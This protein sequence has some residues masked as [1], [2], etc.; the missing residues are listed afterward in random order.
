[1]V[2]S[3]FCVILML[4]FLFQ[5]YPTHSL[6]QFGMKPSE[7]PESNKVAQIIRNF[8]RTY[9][10]DKN[11]YASFFTD[12]GT[13]DQFVFQKEILT[14]LTKDLSVNTTFS[15]FN[16]STS[17]IDEKHRYRYRLPIDLY[18]VDRLDQIRYERIKYSCYFQ[19]FTTMKSFS[20]N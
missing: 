1:M 6:H 4:I 15:F 9:F 13:I 3:K 10:S 11:V 16:I 14:N 2:T 8:I 20:E 7:H 12:A 5:L 18:M 19:I 17:S